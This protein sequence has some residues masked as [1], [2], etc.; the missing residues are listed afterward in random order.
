MK[1]IEKEKTYDFIVNHGVEKGF[2][3]FTLN[4]KSFVFKISE[5]LKKP[6]KI[7]LG[8]GDFLEIGDFNNFID[9]VLLDNE[10]TKLEGILDK[11]NRK[12]AQDGQIPFSFF[13]LA[14]YYPDFL[15]K[16]IPVE[17]ISTIGK[18]GRL[19]PGAEIFVKYIK[20]YDPLILTA[21]PY[22][23]SIEYARRL[24]L[25]NE[26]LLATEYKKY[27][28]NDKIFS[29]DIIKFI[30]GNRRSIEIEKIIVN[31]KKEN[32]ITIDLIRMRIRDLIYTH[33]KLVV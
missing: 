31:V 27:E 12:M 10:V 28:N 5:Y 15:L 9:A 2:E 8:M 20:E 30:S 33:L 32:N 6:K 17:C 14:V 25:D 29:G 26:N 3:V 22:D 23:I 4:K 1:K 13:K 16:D 24:G 19:F 21:I 18:K 11:N 7:F